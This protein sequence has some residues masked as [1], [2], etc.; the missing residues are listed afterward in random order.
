MVKTS[1]SLGS[2]EL[3]L[4]NYFSEQSFL[5]QIVDDSL[6]L[7]FSVEPREDLHGVDD[8]TFFLGSLAFELLC[9]LQVKKASFDHKLFA[10]D[11]FVES[12]VIQFNN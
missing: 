10:S 12:G 9:S 6:V 4:L 3:D 8:L 2:E 5:Y 7:S 11:S 1:K